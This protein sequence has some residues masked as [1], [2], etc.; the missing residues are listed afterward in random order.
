[1]GEQFERQVSTG[2][3]VMVVVEEVVVVDGVAVTTM[4]LEIVVVVSAGAK[5]NLQ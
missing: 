3:S 2:V 5:R 4:V 1:M